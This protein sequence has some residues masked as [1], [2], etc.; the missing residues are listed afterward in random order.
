M[1]AYDGD[2]GDLDDE[3]ADGVHVHWSNG[4][5]ADDWGRAIWCYG[6]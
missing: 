6:L 3:W 5:E 4:D 1:N 2:T